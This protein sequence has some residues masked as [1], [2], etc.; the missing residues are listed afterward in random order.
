MSA[1]RGGV[2][3]WLRSCRTASARPAS[4]VVTAPPSPVVTIL[5]GWKERQPSRPRPPHG[6][7]AAACAQRAGRVLD[8][9]HRRQLLDPRRPAEQVHGDD[10]L[11]PPRR[12][13]PRGIDVHRLRVDVD[14]H[15]PQPGER[16]DVRRGREGVRRDDHLVARPEPER[17]HGQV[18]RGRPGRDRDGVLDART[19][20]ASRPSSSATFGPIVSC[21][22]SS[23]S[24]TAAASSAPDVGPGETDYVVAGCLS[25]YHAI[26]LAR[27]SSRS[28]CASK[29]SS[30][31]ALSTFGIRISTSA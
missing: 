27:P 9:R 22:V 18:Q 10:R 8:Q 19:R 24:A 7:S 30:S 4:F 26:V 21:P 28:T 15:G 25:R 31:R 11:R 14:E 20:G 6:R 13:D 17:E 3:P 16:D 23:T 5:R 12:L 29:P 2:Q 1:S